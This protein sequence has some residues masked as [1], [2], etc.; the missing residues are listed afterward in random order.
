MFTYFTF[1]FSRCKMQSLL[2]FRISNIFTILTFLIC[3]IFHFPY[4]ILHKKIN[5]KTLPTALTNIGFGFIT[6]IR[7]NGSVFVLDE[8][9]RLVVCRAQRA[10]LEK[11]KYQE[12]PILSYFLHLRRVHAKKKKHHKF[13]RGQRG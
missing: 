4:V 11:N 13:L 1:F 10:P 6:V 2:I 12:I 7:I 8:E 5:E 9:T 3:V